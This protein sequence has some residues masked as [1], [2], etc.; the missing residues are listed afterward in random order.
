LTLGRP[1]R[2]QNATQE[3]L[4]SSPAFFVGV[5]LVDEPL[6]APAEDCNSSSWDERHDFSP[7]VVNSKELLVP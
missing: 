3:A 7:G 6:G 5:E 1:V 4:Q 2:V